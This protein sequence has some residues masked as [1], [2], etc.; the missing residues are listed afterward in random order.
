MNY[1]LA[2]Q[3][4]QYKIDSLDALLRTPISVSTNSINT[5]TAASLAGTAETLKSSTGAA[6]S[7]AS[8]AYGNPGST[9]GTT[10]LLTNLATVSRG[11]APAI[12]NHY[13]VQP[14]FD[15]YANV[16]RTRPGQRGNGGGKD[17]RR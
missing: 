17:R 8:S 10:Q 13:N 14:V 5:N 7:G 2:V 6:P 1:Q 3:T 12:V 16:D 4:P 15:V 9:P 11:Y